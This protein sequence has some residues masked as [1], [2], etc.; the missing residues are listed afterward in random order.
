MPRPVGQV[1]CGENVPRKPR[2]LGRVIAHE[3]PCNEI[4]VVFS[5]AAMNLG[6]MIRKASKCGSSFQGRW[7]GFPR[8]QR[9]VIRG[10]RRV[11]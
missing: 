8:L 4:S 3:R 2:A 11:A 5:A 1:A 6:R 7:G 10:N 9:Q